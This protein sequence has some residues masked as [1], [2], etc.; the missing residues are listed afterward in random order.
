MRM[1]TLLCNVM[2]LA[3]YSVHRN[4]RLSVC[5]A[6]TTRIPEPL[7]CSFARCA[8]PQI[9][10]RT[11]YLVPVRGLSILFHSIVQRLDAV[12]RL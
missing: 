12:R 9:N 3:S 1:E 11:S 10:A 2:L 4:R 8:S 7:V 6:P 5:E